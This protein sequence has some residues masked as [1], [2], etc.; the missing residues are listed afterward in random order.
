MCSDIMI[1]IACHYESGIETHHSRPSLEY[2]LSH[3]E[4]RIILTGCKKV[5]QLKWS[6]MY[7]NIQRSHNKTLLLSWYPIY[8]NNTELQG[9]TFLS[10]ICPIIYQHDIFSPLD[11]P[12]YT[13]FLQQNHAGQ[14][15]FVDNNAGNI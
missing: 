12:F 2:P 5:V 9:W 8:L 6:T 11:G 4:L 1:I 14:R 7:H 10:Q 3:F 13:V 15:G